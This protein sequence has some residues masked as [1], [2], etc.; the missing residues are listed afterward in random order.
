MNQIILISIFMVNSLIIN[1]RSLPQE[2][3]NP[4]TPD[5]L[6]LLKYYY[7]HPN[8]DSHFIECDPWGQMSVKEC[9]Q[10][11]K[12]NSWISHCAVVPAPEETNERQK[13]TNLNESQSC[14]F[15]GKSTCQNGGYCN[16]L[17]CFCPLNFV[18]YFCE[19]ASASTG[20][21]A[22]IVNNS[23]SI[24]EY[25]QQRPQLADSQG[26]NATLDTS[27][28][29]DEMTTK[30]LEEYLS[31]YPTGEMRFDSLINFLVQDFLTEL[32]PTSFTLREFLLESEVIVG[33]TSAIPNLL[34]TAKYSFDNFDRFF[35]IFVQVLD[36]LADYLPKQSPLIKDEAK[37]FFD[38][39]DMMLTRSN[40]SNGVFNRTEL[41][42]DEM[43]QIIHQDFNE[44]LNLAYELFKH[45]NHFDDDL[46]L[47]GVNFS[48][49]EM[50]MAVLNFTMDPT[51]IRL[52]SE[53]HLSTHLIRDSMSFYGFWYIVSSYVVPNS[54][55]TSDHVAYSMDGMPHVQFNKQTDGTTLN[56]LKEVTI[57]EPKQPA[58][59][60]DEAMLTEALVKEINRGISSQFD[61]TAGS[62]PVESTTTMNPKK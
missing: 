18:G 53:L 54:T 41:T 61:S 59:E 52:V 42:R 28:V 34:Q 17:K 13:L 5:G 30:R 16:S 55:H 44:T 21:F 38:V 47:R 8:D 36:V 62:T 37:S 6:Y 25:K 46:S 7:P 29:L 24:Q 32:Y 35:N 12:W 49:Y 40:Y 15:Y 45:L 10:G 19:V 56:I 57:D 14:S 2:I 50:Q 58:L 43:R 51:T 22:Q 3:Q 20:A 4:C 60:S 1:G 27:V 33:Y 31:K 26:F 11:T 9:P 48:N 39:Y 23:L